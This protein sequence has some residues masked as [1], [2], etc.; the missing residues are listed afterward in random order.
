[1]WF[2][3]DVLVSPILGIGDV[4][5]FQIQSNIRCNKNEIYTK[6]TESKKERI[7]L[8]IA[9]KRC[10]CVF[11]LVRHSFTIEILHEVK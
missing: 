5:F 1:M 10:V 8:Q 4:F 7:I 6:K 3:I 11:F 9:W 2:L